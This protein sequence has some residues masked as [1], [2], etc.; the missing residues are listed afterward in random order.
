MLYKKLYTW[1]YDIVP[2]DIVTT[3]MNSASK[4]FSNYYAWNSARWF[5]INGE[6]NL[7]D[8]LLFETKKFCLSNFKDSAAWSALLYILIPDEI[9]PKDYIRSDFARIQDRKTN[10]NIKSNLNRNHQLVDSIATEVAQIIDSLVIV[11]W[12]PFL[13]ILSISQL[14]P[15]LPVHSILEK[16]RIELSTYTSKNG[17]LLLIRNH[18]IV[19][20]DDTDFTRSQNIIHF[21]YKKRVLQRANR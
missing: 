15:S 14:M 20:V 8:N 1:F 16:W 10:S 7:R 18:P 3:L 21:G 2:I 4:H 12:P 13:F 19:D 11:E 9:L 6:D 17:E 5:Y